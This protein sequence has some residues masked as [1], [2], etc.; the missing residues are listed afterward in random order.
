MAADIYAAIKE[1]LKL[2]TTEGRE[3]KVHFH[4]RVKYLAECLFRNFQWFQ[5]SF[6]SPVPLGLHA[7]VQIKGHIGSTFDSL[8]SSLSFLR[9]FSL[10]LLSSFLLFF[11][12]FFSFSFSRLPPC[13]QV[14]VCPRAKKRIIKRFLNYLP[15]NFPSLP[16][17]FQ[18]SSLFLSLLFLPFFLFFLSTSE[19]W[20]DVDVQIFGVATVSPWFENS[21]Y[22]YTAYIIFSPH[23][24]IRQRNIH[25][26]YEL[27]TIIP[28]SNL[29]VIYTVSLK[30]LWIS[31]PREFS[32]FF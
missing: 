12:S 32:S 8:S 19:F 30:I 11:L 23:L 13:V 7:R 18:F 20:T 2:R 16:F 17:H 6:R 10:L 14:H 29:H 25:P 31:E 22:G 27:N 9:S 21:V 5:P 1:R 26:E 3:S 28:E 4:N 15:F 24:F